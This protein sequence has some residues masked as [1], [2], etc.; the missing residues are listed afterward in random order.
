MIKTLI[1]AAATC[2]VLSA[3]AFAQ[4]GPAN[5][6]PYGANGAAHTKDVGTNA[7]V[8]DTGNG[9]T[10]SSSM[11]EQRN[12]QDSAAGASSSDYNVKH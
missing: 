7:N 3:P 11:L 4:N 10:T 8:K 6:Q 12:K 5:N 9:R 2:L 1:T